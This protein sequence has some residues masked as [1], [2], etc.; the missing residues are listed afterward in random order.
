M[1]ALNKDNSTIKS[2]CKSNIQNYYVKLLQGKLKG[3]ERMIKS[4]NK[5]IRNQK[6]LHEETNTNSEN[7]E[8]VGKLLNVKEDDDINKLHKLSLI[9]MGA[10]CELLNA[11]RMLVDL[12]IN[13]KVSII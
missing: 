1:Q 2:R 11:N 4:L 12:D 9:N 7:I 10:R 13:L 6:P 8:N 5:S 3:P